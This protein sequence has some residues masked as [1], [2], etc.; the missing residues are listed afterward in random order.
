MMD[1]LLPADWFVYCCYKAYFSK[2]GMRMKN[3]LSAQ[4]I[5]F[6][7]LCFSAPAAVY[8]GGT[9]YRNSVEVMAADEQADIIYKA[10]HV[11]P[12]ARQFQ[13]QKGEFICFIHYPKKHTVYFVIFFYNYGYFLLRIFY[14]VFYP[15]IK[16]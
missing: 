7:L 4:V 9:V 10:A 8:A 3:Y 14:K 2:K 11:V 1:G 15:L 13:W 6:M 5:S 12:S 16:I